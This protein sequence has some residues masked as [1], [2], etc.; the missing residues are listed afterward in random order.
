[1]TF[2]SLRKYPKGADKLNF[3]NIMQDITVQELKHKLDSGE[4]FVFI[5]VR[6][7]WEN[8]E[9]NLGAKLIPL[10]E[11][12]GRIHELEDHKEDEIVIHCR[13]GARSGMAKQLLV[14]QGFTN[15][16]NVLGGILDWQNNYGK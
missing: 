1:M 14:A 2:I 12:M 8:E 11:L 16:R 10:G 9:S 7:V 3:L 13:S 6:E 15:V 4:K 5:D